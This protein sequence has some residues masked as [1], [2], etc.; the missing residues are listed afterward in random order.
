M[1]MRKKVLSTTMAAS[2][3]VLALSGCQEAPETSESNGILH[4]QSAVG[5]QVSDIAEEPPTQQQSGGIYEGTIGS[6]YNKIYINAQIPAIPETV[7]QI[8]LE[9]DDGLDMDTLTV[10]LDSTGG[11]IVDTSQELLE[12]IEKSDYDNT[13]GPEGE[14][15]V[16]SRFGD[17]SVLQI[18]DGEKEAS[19]AYHTGVYYRDSELFDKFLKASSGTTTLIA[20]D[21]MDAGTGFTAREAERILLDK[22]EVL[23]ITE[24]AFERI[25]FTQSS[26]FSYYM[27][28]FVPSYEGIEM[29]IET[30]SYTLGE[31][32]PDG[33]AIVTPDGV[34]E[35]NLFNF[36]GKIADKDPVTVLSFEQIV[37]ILEQYLDS[38]MILTDERITMN[39]VRLEYYPLPNTAPLAGEIETRSELELIPVWHIYMSLDAYVEAGI[40]SYAP[41]NICINAITGE[42]ERIA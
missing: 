8:R 27:M 26:E 16:Y 9:P 35:L 1:S 3:C 40:G 39:N 18:T 19:F 5:Q 4:A 15:A 12:S 6:T 34:A 37:K 20:P 7:Y 17:G 10:F 22:L 30:V 38:N 23:G 33:I 11:N 31:I 41:H 32:Y 14:K 36:C 2:L 28:N 24:V 13:H 25:E 42:I 21:Q 29:I